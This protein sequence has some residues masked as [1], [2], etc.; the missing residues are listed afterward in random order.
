[1]L[2]DFVSQT[3]RGHSLVVTLRV[4]NTHM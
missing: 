3:K 4:L 2:D 1:M